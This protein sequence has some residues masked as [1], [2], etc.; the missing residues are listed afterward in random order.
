MAVYGVSRIVTMAVG[1]P[2]TTT[3]C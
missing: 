1:L 2:T 3:R